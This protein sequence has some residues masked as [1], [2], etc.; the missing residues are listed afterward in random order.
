MS[1]DYAF[2]YCIE[3][4]IVSFINCLSIKIIDMNGELITLL[5]YIFHMHIIVP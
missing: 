2:V 4:A 5:V 1:E 3:Y